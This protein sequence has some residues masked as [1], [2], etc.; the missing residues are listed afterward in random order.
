M[1][2]KNNIIRLDRDSLIKILDGK[3]VS[4]HSVIIKMYAPH[5][6]Y[7]HNLSSY[8]K[9]LSNEYHDIQFFAFNMDDAQNE[10]LEERYGFFGIPSFFHVKTAGK[11]TKIT[12]LADPPNPQPETWYRMSDLKDF[13]DKHK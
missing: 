6:S 1:S 3:V 11:R 7:C 13:I 12:L 8:Y 4:Q 2:T 5:C 10:N 9:D